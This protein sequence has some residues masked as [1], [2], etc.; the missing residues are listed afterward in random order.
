MIRSNRTQ[1]R[2]TRPR[3]RAFTFPEVLVV[4]CLLGIASAIV[5]PQITGQDDLNTSAAARMMIGDLLYAQNRAIAMQ[6]MDYVT[7]DTTAQQYTLFSSM[8]PQTVLEHPV[9]GNSYVMTF[10]Q[11]GQ[12]NVSQ[13]VTLTSASFDG[14]S[15]IAFD[16]TG[17]PYSWSSGTAT[18]LSSP[19]SIVLTCGSYSL[20]ISVSPN[21]GEISVN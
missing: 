19:G 6:T 16:E 15:T 8:S 21:T 20:T 17:I 2:A 18:P 4:V 1:I 9:N 10:G 5:M 13:T 12:N 14:Q 11:T 7:F 3:A